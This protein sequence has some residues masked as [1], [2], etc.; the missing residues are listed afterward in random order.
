MQ[1]HKDVT[2]TFEILNCL[3]IDVFVCLNFQLEA[4]HCHDIKQ[5]ELSLSLPVLILKIILP[6]IEPRFK[7][8]LD[9]E[10]GLN[11]EGERF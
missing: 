6:I 1:K 9:N 11:K 7:Q 3:T 2:L 10:I 8:A 4:N 5:T